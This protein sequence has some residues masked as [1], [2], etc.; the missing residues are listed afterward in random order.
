MIRFDIKIHP[1]DPRIPIIKEYNRFQASYR[2]A[3]KSIAEYAEERIIKNTPKYSGKTSYFWTVD[4]S[5]G[6]GLSA[7]INVHN[8]L[9]SA[10]Y[11]NV[12]TKP[13]PGRYVKAIDRRIKQGWH[14]GIK[15]T[16]YVRKTGNQIKKFAVNRLRKVSSKEF[17][18][19]FRSAS[20]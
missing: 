11:V 2:R 4:S 16:K 9:P 1:K 13:S 20:V 3:I 17:T 6:S 19:V 14:P 12:G 5:I 10:Y 8:P 18:A 15:G 7:N